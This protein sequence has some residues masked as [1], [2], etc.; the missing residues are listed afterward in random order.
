MARIPTYAPIAI[1]TAIAPT[2]PTGAVVRA[3][4]VDWED[5][6]PSTDTQGRADIRA[7]LAALPLAAPLTEIATDVALPNDS[8][9]SLSVTV[10]QWD[11]MAVIV[12]DG[13]GRRTG[14]YLI[15]HADLDSM[16][17]SNASSVSAAGNDARTWTVFHGTH[18]QQV[19]LVRGASDALS[20]G[21][22]AD[23]P[24]AFRLTEI[25]HM[26]FSGHLTEDNWIRTSLFLPSAP[27]GRTDTFFAILVGPDGTNEWDADLKWIS[28]PFLAGRNH[29]NPEFIAEP[30]LFQADGNHVPTQDNSVRLRG[31]LGEGNRDLWIA[32][33]STERIYV[34]TDRSG[35]TPG[36]LRLWRSWGS[37]LTDLGV[38]ADIYGMG[39]RV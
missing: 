34:L 18:H 6:I 31:V 15:P 26:T 9:T 24:E 25:G 37:G 20:A 10:G 21:S 3:R 7:F 36:T 8:L 30:N 4:Q 5:G 35:H 28:A 13:F 22:I 19:G 14:A 11:W 38:T 12:K 23:Y 33:V 2:S 17:V 29:L 39:S 16:P 1:P 32:R 27:S